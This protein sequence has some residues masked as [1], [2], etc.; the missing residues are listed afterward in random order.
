MALM[1]RTSFWSSRNLYFLI[2]TVSHVLDQRHGRCVA[3]SD[4]SS[5]K[6]YASKG[7]KAQHVNRNAPFGRMTRT[8]GIGSI[9]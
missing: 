5:L 6:A 9:V 3:S 1:G 7:A 8:A 4:L 2:N